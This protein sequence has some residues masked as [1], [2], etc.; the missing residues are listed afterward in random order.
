MGVV[1]V[2]FHGML[3]FRCLVQ[4]QVSSQLVMQQGKGPNILKRVAIAPNSPLGTI[5]T[6]PVGAVNRVQRVM[7]SVSMSSS[8]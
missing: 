8:L 6:L 5:K 4:V 7:I 1:M 3:L 2:S